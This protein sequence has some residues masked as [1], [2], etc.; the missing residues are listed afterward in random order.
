MLV[1]DRQKGFNL[2]LNKSFTVIGCGGIGYWVAKFL[3]MSGVEKLIVYDDDVIDET[4]RNRLDLPEALIGKNK[5]E[6]V[7]F[8]VKRLRSDCTVRSVPFK[9]KESLFHMNPTDVIIDCTDN[10]KSQILNESIAKNNNV[11]YC[12]S[13]YDGYHM[14]ISNSIPG[15]GESEDGYTVTPS[16]VVPSVISAALTVAKVLKFFDSE[17]SCNIQDLFIIE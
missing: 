1:Y 10:E 15:W 3:A 12:K 8:V 16:W 2:S 5:S 4:N 14:T 7:K 13:G 9:F 6:I 17:L 11:K